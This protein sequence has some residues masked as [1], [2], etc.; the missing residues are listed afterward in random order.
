VG[1]DS[2]S[3]KFTL[4]NPW[5]LAGG[6]V[7]LNG[8]YYYCAGTLT[9]TGSQLASKFGHAGE[10]GAVATQLAHLDRAGEATALAGNGAADPFGGSRRGSKL[11]GMPLINQAASSGSSHT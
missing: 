7:K 8:K 6:D 5:G 3:Q 4:F 1:Y 2:S 11:I 9:A 10:A